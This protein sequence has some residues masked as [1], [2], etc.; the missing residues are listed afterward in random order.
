MKKHGCIFFLQKVQKMFGILEKTTVKFSPKSGQK[1]IRYNFLNYMG[2]LPPLPIPPFSQETSS[3][4]PL[5]RASDPR[6]WMK[7]NCL[8]FESTSYV[9]L[10]NASE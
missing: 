1:I 3:P 2:D 4:T 8:K 7:D 6:A 9:L 5:K 10:V